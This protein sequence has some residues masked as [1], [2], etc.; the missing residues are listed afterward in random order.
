MR[1]SGHRWLRVAS[2]LSQRSAVF[3]PGLFSLDR[4]ALVTDLPATLHPARLYRLGTFGTLALADPAGDTVL[5]THGHHKRRL[6]LLAV[7]AAAGDRGRSRDQ[8]LLLFWPEATQSRARHSLDQLLYA[9]RGSISESVFASVNPVRLNGDV[10]ASDVGAFNDALARGNLDEA[11]AYYRGPFLDGFYLD[12]SPEF[13]WW[14]ETERARLAVSFAGALERLARAA[15]SERNYVAAVRWWRAL[16]A[17]DPLSSQNAAG[18]IR[19]LASGG[20][21][22]A[23]LQHAD[24]HEALVEK[25]LGTSAGPV[26][27]ELVAEVRARA[28]GER[29]FVA[30]DTA[31]SFALP[32]SP[33]RASIAAPNEA[34]PPSTIHRR[35]S[36]LRI[37]GLALAVLASGAALFANMRTGKASTRADDRPP[38]TSVAA[39]ELVKRANNP[40]VI[41][42]D[43]AVLA[44]LVWVR[45]AI[46]LDS[47]YAAAYATLARLEV[48]AQ[49][50]TDS[51]PRATRLA[52]AEAAANKA[53][54]LDS[55]LAEGYGA[56]QAV[57]RNQIR[58]ASAER[59]LERAIALDPTN[60]RY[61]EW[62]VQLH[63]RMERP[64]QALEEGK[65]AVELDRLS[66]TANAEYAAALIANDRC[67][68]ALVRLESVR[69]LQIPLLRVNGLL[70]RC[71][72]RKRMWP[73]AIASAQRNVPAGGLS[74]QA[75]LAHTFARA[76]RTAEARRILSMLLERSQMPGADPINVALAYAGLGESDQAFSWT[77]KAMNV[78]ALNSS[79]GTLDLIFE[80]LQA[81]PRTDL[82]RR[83]ISAIQNR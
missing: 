56:L 66:P 27:A 17:A 81:D 47:N 8:L 72:I 77:E 18:L 15:E 26:I 62:M 79:W 37:A 2:D 25:E 76:G 59:A 36:T 57:R 83:R 34:V 69:T 9:L 33:N 11:V 74:A 51:V 20:D 65:R 75:M 22:A 50:A 6:A 48:R 30:S 71:Y 45:Q 10:V 82:Y 28:K 31:P 32:S 5:G 55:M 60:P 44:A 35:P 68:D 49:S 58:L 38:T 23:A 63:L 3:L 67:D 13:E 7:L 14:V 1:R 64:S 54:E 42:N 53:I 46:A 61:H 43:S 12:D 19:A 52:A 70:G 39:Y 78:E 21:H 73:A 29:G 16:T 41:R 24:Q 80:A 40:D 4:F